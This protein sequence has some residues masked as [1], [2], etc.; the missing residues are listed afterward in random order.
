MDKPSNNAGAAFSMLA[1]AVEKVE[2]LRA[3]L[4]E[5]HALIEKMAKH[6][7]DAE[8]WGPGVVEALSAHRQWKEK[9]K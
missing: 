3:E 4:E 9:Q 5:A 2:S 7:S 6:L 1:L 8:D